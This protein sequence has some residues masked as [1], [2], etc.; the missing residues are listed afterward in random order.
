MRGKD[1]NNFY[2]KRQREHMRDKAETEKQRKRD[3]E[4]ERGQIDKDGETAEETK[5]PICKL[6]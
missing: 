1:R 2:A 5:R 3:G 6:R 4:T